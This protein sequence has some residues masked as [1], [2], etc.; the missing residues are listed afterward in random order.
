MN[1]T[2][3]AAVINTIKSATYAADFQA[4]FGAAVLDDVNKAY[5]Y[6]VDAI[7]A[8]ERS[9]TFSPFNSKFDL[10]Q[11]GAATFTAAEARGN[12]LFN[13][14]AQCDTCHT[15]PGSDEE[16]F[17]DF[18]YRNIGVPANTALETARGGGAINDL[19][20]G[21]IT[22]QVA[23]NGRFRTSS[24]RNIA[25]TA[26]YMHNGVFADLTEVMNFYN[27]RDLDGITPEVATNVDNAGDIGE[28]NLDAGEVSDLVD[29]LETLTD[30]GL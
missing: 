13:G 23:D 9:E 6:V 20:L 18:E 4:L 10:V 17:S 5:D 7:A 21:A 16:V 12:A 15:T 2:D 3:E 19:G 22:G 27:R 24:L 25:R 29:F 11:T 8:F 28:L 30:A 14:K 26:P 1:N